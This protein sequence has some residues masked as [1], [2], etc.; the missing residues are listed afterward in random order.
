MNSSS[1]LPQV[2]E[3]VGGGDRRREMS[4]G[5][6]QRHLEERKLAREFRLGRGRGSECQ[7]K[8]GMELL[9]EKSEEAGHKEQSVEQ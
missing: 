8:G 6:K 7:E 5:T 2:R 3:L 4:R 1:P 9:R